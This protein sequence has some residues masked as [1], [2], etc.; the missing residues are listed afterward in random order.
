M[1]DDG[2]DDRE[3]VGQGCSLRYWEGTYHVGSSSTAAQASD[4][5]LPFMD[6]LDTD[7]LVCIKWGFDDQQGNITFKFIV[8]TTGWIGFGLSPNGDMIGAD[9]V[10]GGVG[11]DGNYFKDYYSTENS[12]P[13]EDQQQSYTLLALNESDG[14]TLMTFSRAL[15]TCDHQDLPI[16][17]QPMK[18]IYAYGLTDEIGFHAALAGSKELNLLNYVTRSTAAKG[19]YIS[20]T[21][22]NITIPPQ[23]TYY[24]CRVM[25]FPTFVTK[26]H[27]IQFEP[28][29]EN[30]DLVHHMLLYSCPSSVTTAYDGEC[31]Q[32][33]SG[34]RCYA[35]V[36]AWAVGSQIFELPENTGIPIGG[37]E[38]VAFYRLE[39]HY[40]NLNNVSGRIDSSGLKLHYTD[41][42]RP[43]DVGILS[44]GVS[45]SRH[46]D[47]DIPPRATK[48]R[49]YGVCNTSLISQ[50]VNPVPD[51]QVFAVMM[52]T[53]TAGREIRVGHFRNGEQ[54]GFLAMNLNYDF[55]LQEI[56]RL[57]SI[58]TIKPGDD[59]V[60]EC[61]YST[62]D[63]TGATQMGL[64]TTDEMCL[65][66][67]LFYPKIKIV[68][69][70]SQ[71]NMS[72][73]NHQ[74]PL[75]GSVSNQEEIVEYENVVKNL[76]QI[77]ILFTNDSQFHVNPYGHV[78]DMME[79]RTYHCEHTG[80]GSSKCTSGIWNQVS[81]LVV[82]VWMASS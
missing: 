25:K 29:I 52:H 12:Y 13:I 21:M 69:C 41:Q 16:T 14:Q 36:G 30:R 27:I 47:Y 42:L 62:S 75:G 28:V 67:L 71:P 45:P 1:I 61:S 78:R 38:D 60:V 43:H 58:K 4:P 6:Y 57:G 56:T 70:F 49:T 79:T 10:M 34:D 31:Y 77:Q 7:H 3:G 5:S 50:I 40:S 51:L 64:A 39:I 63:R 81:V 20:A 76:S 82:L 44:T 54:L 33:H 66:F 74:F 11:P 37:G 26:H 18:L 23:D 59:I 17:A 73:L 72:N 48:F 68:A 55:N 65:A 2:W 9:L 22:E 8:N 53:H 35:I 32:G 19:N 24:H 15:Q 80:N 46:I